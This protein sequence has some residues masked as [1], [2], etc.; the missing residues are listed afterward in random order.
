ME[1]FLNIN[2]KC[3]SEETNG[4]PKTTDKVVNNRK[5]WKYDDSYLDF[6]FTLLDVSYQEH[7]QYVLCVKVLSPD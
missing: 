5:F 6:G 4:K 1:S 7:L 3:D 2:K